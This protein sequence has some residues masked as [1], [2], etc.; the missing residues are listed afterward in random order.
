MSETKSNQIKGST[1]AQINFPIVGI[2]SSAGGLEATGDLLS[3][4]PPDTGMAYVIIQH[5]DPSHESLLSE[6]LARKTAMQVNEVVEDTEVVPNCIY[7]I[8]PNHDLEIVDGLLKLRTRVESLV[9][10]PIDLFFHSLAS[11]HKSNS[12]GVILS[13]AAS[14]GTI[15][16][17][18]IKAEGG[19]TLVQEPT[20]AK[21]DGMPR[22][23][24]SSGVV[25]IVGT[26]EE[27][28]T[29]LIRFSKYPTHA[30][31][32]LDSTLDAKTKGEIDESLRKIFAILRNGTHADFTYYKGSTIQRRI[33]RRLLVLNLKD[34]ASYAHFLEKHPEEVQ[35]LFA[36]ILIHVTSFFREPK[37]FEMLRTEVLPHYMKNRD[38]ELPFRLWV[39]GCSTGEEAY[40]IAITFL[41]FLEDAGIQVR[42]NIFASD[43]SEFALNKARK[44]IYPRTIEA[45][46]STE[47]LKRYF[48]KTD[49][50]YK[51]AKRIRDMCIFSRHD[52][53]SDPPFAKLDMISCRNLLIYFAAPLQKYVFPLFHYALKPEGILWLGSAESVGEFT[54]LF[55]QKNSASKFYFKKNFKLPAKLQLPLKSLPFESSRV[56]HPS[57]AKIEGHLDAQR[58]LDKIAFSAYVPPCV[59]INDN[60][61]ILYTRGRTDPYLALTTGQ[62]NFNLLRMVHPELIA[63]LRSTI[64]EARQRGQAIK[65]EHLS[66]HDKK[67]VLFV[68]INVVPLHLSPSTKDQHFTIFFEEDRPPE[69]QIAHAYS[70][71]DGL[72]QRDQHLLEMERKV[73][74]SQEY[75]QSLVEQFGTAQEELTSSNEELQST[76]EE[77]QSTNEELETAKEELQSINEE[78][79]N[80]NDQLN[81]SNEQIKKAHDDAATI[82]RKIPIPLVTIGS[83][84]R[85]IAANEPFYEKFKAVPSATEGRLFTDLSGGNWNIPALIE[86]IDIVLAKGTEFQDYEVEHNFINIGQMTMI[87]NAKKV[88]LPGSGADAVLVAIEDFTER[89]KTEQKLKLAEDRYRSLLATAHEGILIIN[90]KGLIDFVNN[91]VEELFCYDS[92]ELLGKPLGVLIPDKQ[93]LEQAQ[94]QGNTAEASGLNIYGRRKDGSVLSVD[95]SLSPVKSGN[96]IFVTAI[97][98][99]SSVREEQEQETARVLEVETK[100][101]EESEKSN[102][103]KDEFVATLSH[104][105]RTPLASILSW[106]QLIRSG[107]LDAQKVAKGIE[108]IE[109]SAKTQSQ[110]ID[111]LLDISRIQTNKLK[112]SIQRIDP[113]KVIAA[114]IDS[115]RSL[116]ASKSIQIETKVDPS[117]SYIEV[118]PMRLQQILWNLITNAIKFSPHGGRVWINVDRAESQANKRIRFQVRDNGKGLKPEFLPVIFERFT[119]VDSS[120][121]RVYG[122]LGLGLAI[123]RKLVGMHKGTI[124]VDSPGEGKGTT[125][126]VYLPEKS[127]VKVISTESEADTEDESV[128]EIALDGLRVLLV[129]DEP[130]AREV[131]GVM[132][133]SFGA[134]VKTASSVSEALTL[135]KEFKP[136][137]LVSDIAMPGEDGYSL[138]ERVRAMKSP[139]AKIPALALTAYAGQEDIQ[140][141]HLSG[142][143]SHLGKP[144]DRCKLALAI[145]R[146]AGRK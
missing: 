125:F 52:L 62:P 59:L 55:G 114:A 110:I 7:V 84:K 95:I 2:G 83:D 1:T 115:T 24:I 96:E 6:I 49:D 39:A 64:Q 139:L 87:L 129:D 88:R 36:D 104:E 47:R 38:Q 54:N 93:L 50:G 101:R 74:V 81:I 126:T 30:T 85:V 132:I 12:I 21:Y 11:D 109:Q 131:F 68:N 25:D 27:I 37:R 128:V 14:D 142:F 51:I 130:N 143:Q 86:M 79:T 31:S 97:I 113:E 92:G 140:R 100:A 90:S 135:L 18:S 48:E 61:D 13:G 145:A 89:K 56:N 16:L 9:H 98:R 94:S 80:V 20:S 4:L 118:D 103:S 111:D 72:K 117:I 106:A 28:A 35:A 108:T 66:I 119:Q 122:G 32:P 144:V 60:M 22:S 99:D 91:T 57:A 17:E 75:Q 29:E 124:E 70:T 8:P 137:V 116:A 82:L 73:S 121:T 71:E 102:R 44:G 53:I 23:A 146:L 78:L 15:G 19:F 127:R 46:V 123:V 136:E 107:K 26:P 134:E 69:K 63:E 105:L 3:H 43:I 5:L 138:I 141:A 133:Q 67:K 10:M 33:S 77:L 112:L 40:S 58:E 34:L 65:R 41:E 120:S 42:L 76:N 45:D